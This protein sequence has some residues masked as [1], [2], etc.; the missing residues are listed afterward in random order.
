MQE[1]SRAVAACLSPGEGPLA[2]SPGVV[3]QGVGVVV[4]HV[5]PPDLE[6]N[7]IFYGVN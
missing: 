2:V 4:V 3:V 6:R 5:V 7:T 1:C